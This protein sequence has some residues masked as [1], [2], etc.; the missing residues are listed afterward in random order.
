MHLLGK[1]HLR[2]VG[3]RASICH[4]EETRACVLDLEVLV[5][6]LLAVD[7]LAACAILAREVTALEHELKN[8][9]NKRP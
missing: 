2:A 3:V 5:L 4:G 7:G 9:L 1:T 8:K 6:E